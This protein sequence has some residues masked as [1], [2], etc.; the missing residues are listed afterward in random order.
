ML[1]DVI[2][3]AGPN[4]LICCD[5]YNFMAKFNY[6]S[7]LSSSFKDYELRMALSPQNDKA[8]LSPK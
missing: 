4:H 6:S 2:S 8:V 7:P 3:T 1:G 5:S